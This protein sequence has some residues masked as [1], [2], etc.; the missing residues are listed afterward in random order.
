MNSEGIRLLNGRW[1]NTEELANL[2]GVDA[3][4]V[5][6]WRTARPPQ[7]PPFVQVSERVT[8]YNALDVEAW[9]RSKRVDPAAAA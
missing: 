3:S 8:M 7:G 2:L 6:R 4:T 1:Y 5:R 9:L